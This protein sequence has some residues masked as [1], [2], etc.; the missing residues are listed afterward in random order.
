MAALSTPVRNS[1]ELISSAGIDST[2]SALGRM[3]QASPENVL[4]MARSE[5]RNGRKTNQK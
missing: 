3:G 2:T 1:S 4:E 5:V